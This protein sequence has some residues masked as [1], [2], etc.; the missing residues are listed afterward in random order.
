MS[1]GPPV[2]FDGAM[3]TLL[4]RPSKDALEM[5]QIIA[6]GYETA[7]VW[8]CWQWVKQ[9]LWL[10]D[11]DAEEILSGLP[12]WRHNYQSVRTAKSGQLP[13]NGDPVP[14]SVHGMALTDPR[15]V[16]LLVRGFLTAINVAIVMQRGIAPSVTEP[17]ELKV[18]GEDF[19]REVNGKAGTDLKVDQLFGVLRGEPATWRG[20]TQNAGRESWNLTDVRLSRYVGIRSVQDYLARL[21]ESVGF[22]QATP[23]ALLGPMALPDAL[24]HLDL[25]W[26]LVTSEHLVR[27]PRVATA[28]K[29]SV[30]HLAFSL[31]HGCCTLV[32]RS[33]PRSCRRRGR[34]AT[35]PARTGN[36]PGLKSSW[37]AA[38]PH[39]RETRAARPRSLSRQDQPGSP[40]ATRPG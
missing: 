21:E 4:D 36:R 12:T 15:G 5:L 6:E 16:C 19:I 14:L 20:I 30:S 22:S 29:L 37:S 34:S 40:P 23:R 17:M 7:G 1:N 11:L 2:C 31:F 10:K 39:C 8:P 25:A 3:P 27:V 26:R 28:A 32:R 13:D 9:Q 33:R 35:G 24:D 38:R 18:A